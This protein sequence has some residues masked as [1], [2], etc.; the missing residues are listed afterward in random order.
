MLQQGLIDRQRQRQVFAHHLQHGRRPDAH[1]VDMIG[2]RD[3]IRRIGF[4]HDCRRQADR[5]AA[6]EQAQDH[7]VAGT[8]GTLDFNDAVIDQ[9]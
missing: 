1:D 8:P 9:R 4:V 7:A 3:G 2:K 6:G 5:L